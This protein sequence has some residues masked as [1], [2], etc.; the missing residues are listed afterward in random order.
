[1]II[2]FVVCSNVNAFE[3]TVATTP[4]VQQI[5]VR[6]GISGRRRKINNTQHEYQQHIVDSQKSKS[7]RDKF[8]GPKRKATQNQRK[9]N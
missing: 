3:T 9:K 4:I 8:N 2:G 6:L 5:K 1:M 7:A